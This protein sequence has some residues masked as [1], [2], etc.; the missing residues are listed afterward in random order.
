MVLCL[1]G[2]LLAGKPLLAGTTSESMH[3]AEVGVKASDEDGDLVA[4]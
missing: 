1:G 3:Q 2:L 4:V